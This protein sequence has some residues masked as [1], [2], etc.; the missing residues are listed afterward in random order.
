M[1]VFKIDVPGQADIRKIEAPSYGIAID[2]YLASHGLFGY[3]S[4]NVDVVNE[5][6]DDDLEEVMA[7]Y[8]D[9]D[10][11]KLDE[12]HHAA[13]PL[14][15]SATKL[16]VAV[17]LFRAGELLIGQRGPACRRGRGCFA[18]PGGMVER[19]EPILN[20]ARREVLEETGLTVSFPE[21]HFQLS[22]LAVT[23][24]MPA[25]DLVTFWM[26]ADGFSGNL[27][28]REP[29]KCVGWSWHSLDWIEQNIPGSSDESSEQHYWLPYPLLRR[30]L[31]RHGQVGNHGPTIPQN[32]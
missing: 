32:R 4:I 9:A 25:E 19:P 7:I 14:P 26:L 5:A 15:A 16:G 23:D 12:H 13:R 30:N 28:T 8:H 21:Q 22:C 17:L 20:A 31:A 2:Y 1:P 27:M 24:H 10:R 6:P 18:L 29:A 11:Q 3:D